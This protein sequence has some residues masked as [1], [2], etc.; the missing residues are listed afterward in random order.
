MI[1]FDNDIVSQST[2]NRME[3][4][5]Y[6]ASAATYQWLAGDNTDVFDFWDDAATVGD[7]IAFG[8]DRA[9]WHDLTVNVGTVASGGASFALTVVWE[10]YTGSSWVALPGVTDNTAGFTVVGVNAVTF[11]VPDN[12][13]VGF[14]LNGSYQCTAHW[15]R[16]KITAVTDMTEGGAHAT[17]YATGLDYSIA[18]TSSETPATAKTANDAGGWGVVTQ[19]GGRLWYVACNVRLESGGTLTIEQESV[20]VGQVAN[21]RW[22]QLL[23][24]PGSALV[25]GRKTGSEYSHGAALFLNGVYSY[26]PYNY[27]YGSVTAYN[28]LIS[29][30]GAHFDNAALAGVLD[31]RGSVLEVRHGS[32]A[33]YVANSATG[34]MANTSIALNGGNFYVYSGSVSMSG[35][36]YERGN[37]FYVRSGAVVESMNL[38]SPVQRV[39]VVPSTSRNATLLNC[40]ISDYSTQCKATPVGSVL[41]VKYDLELRVIDKHGSLL[42]GA[43]VIVRNSEGTVVLEGDT[44][45]GILKGTLTVWQEAAGVE[46]DFGMFECW[47]FLAGK[48]VHYERFDVGH[49]NRLRQI[50][51]AAGFMASEDASG[52]EWR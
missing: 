39:A 42:A 12:W 21:G 5:R 46:T 15:I 14:R 31:I 17:N 47:V 3:V 28:S 38:D 30:H 19:A 2:H 11:S 48:Q 44:V 9:V 20:A 25:L 29:W 18:L 13:K 35:L 4:L 43:H 41:Y 45:A 36:S 37:G 34:S 50:P 40:V 24:A 10:Y 33:L 7:W 16:C 51:L 6:D 49:L 26:E 23:L 27:W 8:W 1:T 32:L 22:R 52:P